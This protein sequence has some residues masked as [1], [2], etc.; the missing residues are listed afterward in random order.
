MP[1]PTPNRL[2]LSAGFA[3][4]VLGSTACRLEAQTRA[5][6][7]FER[8]LTVGGPVTLDI[9]TGSGNIEIHSGPAEQHSGR[10]ARARGAVVVQRRRRRTDT[11]HRGDA[12]DHTER[13]RSSPRAC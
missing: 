9:R 10:R 7:M 2:M 8:T 4:L 5:E 12:A 3:L 1:N 6:G 13:R 11:A